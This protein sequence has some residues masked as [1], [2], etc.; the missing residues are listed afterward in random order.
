VEGK[1]DHERREE[2]TADY[3]DYA[4]EE[5]TTKYTK[6]TKRRP[7]ITQITQRKR[8]PRNARNTRKKEEHERRGRRRNAKDT[9]D[10]K[11]RYRLSTKPAPFL[12]KPG[13]IR[14]GRRGSQKKKCQA[15]NLRQSVK[16]VDK[17]PDTSADCAE[18]RR[19]ILR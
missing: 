5:G 15:C 4:E 3:T 13:F 10:A 12:P 1:M 16:Y 11:K 18:D 7:Q 19:R 17:S 14:R 2:G 9:K 8:G 6:G